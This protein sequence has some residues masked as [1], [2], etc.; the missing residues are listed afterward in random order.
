MTRKNFNER[1]VAIRVGAF[2]YV[3]EISDR[4]MCVNQ[5]NQFKFPHQ[6]TSG[7]VYSI[8]RFDRTADTDFA[9]GLRNG[10]RVA[11]DAYGAG[12][13]EL[14]QAFAEPGD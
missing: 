4:L 12:T 10:L 5:E 3:V 2:K 14:L 8:T 13:C 6:R 7:T 9:P 11:G 1:Q